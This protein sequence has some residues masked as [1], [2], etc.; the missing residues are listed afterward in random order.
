MLRF[1]SFLAFGLIPFVTEEKRKRELINL[2]GKARTSITIIEDHD[3]D[4]AF[5]NDE[6]IIAVLKQ[7]INR[8]VAIQ[9]VYHPSIKNRLLNV[10]ILRIP[11]VKVFTTDELLN[12][13]VMIVDEKDVVVEAM[14]ASGEKRIPTVIKRNDPSLAKAF[15]LAFKTLISAQI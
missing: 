4:E 6:R 3:L 15:R 7:A 1:L 9:I 14:H 8:G 2:F 12:R 13:G 11:G 10:S 5:Y